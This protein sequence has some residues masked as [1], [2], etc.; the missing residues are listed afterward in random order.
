MADQVVSVGRLLQAPKPMIGGQPREACR[1]SCRVATVRV[2][3]EQCLLAGRAPQSADQ[4]RVID[5]TG[6][7]L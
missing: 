6:T 1:L 7:R 2:R 5:R 4:L 3:V